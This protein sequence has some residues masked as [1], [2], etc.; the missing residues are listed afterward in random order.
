[1]RFRRLYC[2]WSQLQQQTSIHMLIYAQF[3]FKGC[4]NGWYAYVW[5]H[6]LPRQHEYVAH[7][8][9]SDTMPYTYAF[10]CPF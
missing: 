6:S 3:I 1:M 9:L 2:Q 4:Y 8:L 7:G 5:L 10:S